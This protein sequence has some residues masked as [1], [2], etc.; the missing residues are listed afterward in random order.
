MHITL[1]RG[2][3]D[4]L[5]AA[6]DRKAKGGAARGGSPISLQEYLEWEILAPQI[7]GHLLG[8]SDDAGDEGT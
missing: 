7:K 8:G 1:E 2:D 5:E 4:H 3:V 6:S